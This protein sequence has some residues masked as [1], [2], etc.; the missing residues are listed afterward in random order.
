M[1][2]DLIRFLRGYVVFDVSG[3]FPERFI[4]ITSR[5]S[6]R[7]WNAA[8]SGEVITA[9]MYMS[10]YRRI[11]PLA[12]A[13]GVRL[14]AR[15]K[16]GLPTYVFRFRDRVGLVVGGFV[17]ILTVF[18]MSQFIWSVEITGLET[19]SESEMRSLLSAHGL[20][21]GAFKPG[22]NYQDISRSVMLDNG[23][24][25]WMA[26]NVTGS[27]ASV[28]I[29]EEA[30]APELPDAS[31]PANVKARRDGTILRIE[32]GEGVC[33]L[34]EGSGVAAGQ[35]VVSGVI[36]N[37]LGGARLVRADASVIAATAYAVEFSVPERVEVMLPNGERG[38]R[39][40]LDLFGLRLPL[41]GYA[42]DAGDS[43]VTDRFDSLEVLDTALPVGVVT[44]SVCGMEKKRI[45]YDDNSAE[46]LLMKQAQLY[47]AFT[48]KDCTVTD[49]HYRFDH[50]G[51]VYTLGVTYDCVEDI[52]VQTPIGVE[53]GEG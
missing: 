5:K 38:E 4:N 7:V 6:I 15:Q 43:A 33:L 3:R 35:L 24:V 46:E 20:Y 40:V 34:K 30:P 10:D 32:T 18:V 52:A 2:L 9:A 42:P 53:K 28:E 12:R 39:R 1:L 27:Y 14:K 16:R 11:R 47:E 41:S 21:V 51:G 22:L 37:K 49:R 48:L 17:F 13:A 19:V 31:Q 50:S 26:V 23:K 45:V 44:E 29:K 36:E 25:G 8:R